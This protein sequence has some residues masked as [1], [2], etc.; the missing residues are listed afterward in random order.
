MGTKIIR[1]KYILL[2]QLQVFFQLHNIHKT[3]KNYEGVK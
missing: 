2:Y 1:K 3:R